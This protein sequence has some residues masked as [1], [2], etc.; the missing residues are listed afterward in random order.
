M[1]HEPPYGVVVDPAGWRLLGRATVR[2]RIAE[3]DDVLDAMDA[4]AGEQQRRT[5]PAAPVLA[6]DGVGV[7]VDGAHEKFSEIALGFCD[8]AGRITE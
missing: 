7:D 8:G 6:Q 5:Q 4:R 1:Q 2:Q 3:R